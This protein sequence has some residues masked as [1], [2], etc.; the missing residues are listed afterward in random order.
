MLKYLL[1]SCILL[2]FVVVSDAQTPTFQANSTVEKD[3]QQ[4]LQK[5][6]Y[7]FQL[8]DLPIEAI[9][10]HVSTA[11]RSD[12]K[13]KSNQNINW[14]IELQAYDIR[15]DHYALRSATENGVKK[16]EAGKNITY[17][18][19]LA[20][21]DGSDVRLTIAPGFFYGMVETNNTTYYIEPLSYFVV[22][23]DAN[24]FVI[25]E[26]ADVIPLTGKTC[27]VTEAHRRKMQLEQAGKNK[28]N[29]NTLTALGPCFE[30]E[31]AIASDFSMFTKYGNSTLNVQNHNIAVMNNVQT[32]YDDEFTNNLNFVIVENFVSSCST[33][34]PWTS[35]TNAGTLLDAA[36]D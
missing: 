6:F 22:G 8:F 28:N 31:M 16:L 10:Q 17:R 24:Q 19:R 18:G 4:I 13:L 11:D 2:L 25:Y 15:G 14:D 32:N 21:I 3:A 35:S 9:H 34:D 29:D 12:F 30:V 1:S 26:E 33:C 7:D 5:Q 20:N 36:L 27:G 23:A